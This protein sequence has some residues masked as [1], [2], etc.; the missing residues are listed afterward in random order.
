VDAMTDRSAEAHEN[1]IR[2][3]FPRLGETGMTQDIIG[4][5]QARTV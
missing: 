2:R 4:M 5:L 3:I 1:S